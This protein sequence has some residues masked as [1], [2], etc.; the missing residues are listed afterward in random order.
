MATK[1]ARAH[2]TRFDSEC[3]FCRRFL[4]DGIDLVVPLEDDYGETDW[5]CVECAKNEGYDVSEP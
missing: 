5:V 1:T 2:Y 3:A 4:N